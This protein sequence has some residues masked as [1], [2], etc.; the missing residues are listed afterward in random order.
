M[1]SQ[2]KS[3]SDDMSDEKISSKEATKRA[4]MRAAEAKAAQSEIKLQKLLRKEE[5]ARLNEE[6]MF[7]TLSEP[8]KVLTWYLRNQ[9][10]IEVNLI[11][12]R[13]KKA[14][15]I[16]RISTTVISGLIVFHDYIDKNVGNGHAVS[17]ILIFG[18]LVCPILL[19]GS[20]LVR[21]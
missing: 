19:M 1:S 20:I 14:A 13:D 3:V 16:I 7:G 2:E 15:I 4:K 17:Q 8:R 18:L 11:N 6:G 21:E 12:I 5:E 9:N 10:K